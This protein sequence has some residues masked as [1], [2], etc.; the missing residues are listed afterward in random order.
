MTGTSPRDKSG[1]SSPDAA[2]SEGQSS[3]QVNIDIWSQRGRSISRSSSVHPSPSR[4]REGSLTRQAPSSSV[5]PFGS[6]HSSSQPLQGDQPAP[7]DVLRDLVAESSE[8]ALHGV[9]RPHDDETTDEPSAKR[10]KLGEEL[11]RM[12]SAQHP[13]AVPAP[14]LAA[15]SAAFSF[16]SA[17]V[18]HPAPTDDGPADTR[19]LHSTDVGWTSSS[20]TLPIRSGRHHLPRLGNGTPISRNGMPE[21]LEPLSSSEGSSDRS[22]G[23][24]KT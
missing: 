21:E 1:L 15:G 24:G 5:S 22:F 6:S 20:G 18:G 8:P 10:D 19:L 9:K 12:S 4:G 3:V 14:S 16:T 13:L 7:E 11:E 17:P 2:A 23:D